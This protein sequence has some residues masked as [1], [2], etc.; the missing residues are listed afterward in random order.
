MIIRKIDNE[1]DWTAG[2]GKNNYVS[3]A[4][5]VSQNIRTRLNSFLGDCFF[6][7]NEGIDWFNLLGTNR[8]ADIKLSIATTILNTENVTE[9]NTI[10]YTVD[11]NRG[12]IISYSAESNFGTINESVNQEL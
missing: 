3:G 9:L 10:D 1:G 12:L 11:K 7:L 8:E 5:A 6:S 2:K 4:K